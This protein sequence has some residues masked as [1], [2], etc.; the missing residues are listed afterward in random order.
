M[1]FRDLEK[2]SLALQGKFEGVLYVVATA[3][4]HVARH[5]YDPWKGCRGI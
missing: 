1:T 3:P 5:R 2:V 4:G